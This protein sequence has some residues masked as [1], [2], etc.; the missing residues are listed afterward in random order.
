MRE[1][2]NG[3]WADKKQL[4]GAVAGTGITAEDHA[5]EH[6]SSCG[7]LSRWHVEIGFQV[8]G[9]EHEND[10]VEGFVAFEAGG[11]VGFA[12]AGSVE[13]VV[14]HGGPAVLP[15]FNDA[16][17]GAQLSCQD[18]CPA[19]MWLMPYGIRS[20]DTIGAEAPSV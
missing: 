5:C 15:F 7:D 13:R 12:V 8:V 2:S 10:C 19:H 18:T 6:S 11:E 9:A 16:P 14:M 4:G 1:V 3:R 20:G 17:F